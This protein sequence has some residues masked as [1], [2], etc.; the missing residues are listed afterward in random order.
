MNPWNRAIT[1]TN[2]DSYI[3][4]NELKSVRNEEITNFYDKILNAT[5][6]KTYY[7]AME[8]NK[9]NNPEFN[10]ERSYSINQI[11]NFGRNP[12]YT[13]QINNISLNPPNSPILYEWDSVPKVTIFFS[14]L[15]FK[16]QYIISL[17]DKICNS[18]NK[19]Q[20]CM[21]KTFCSCLYTYEFELNDV[22]EFV[23]V[24]EGFTFQSNHPMHLHGHR[25]AVL[26]LDKV[27]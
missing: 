26:G 4:V 25:Y 20:V 10:D 5:N 7:L 3:S 23:I 11:R 22:V 24:D 6:V 18:M 14:C 1:P 8:F 27:R 9:I 2:R 12:L 19:E 21:N 15:K 13:P 17:K 16:T